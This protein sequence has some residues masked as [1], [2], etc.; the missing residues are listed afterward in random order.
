[1]LD[2]FLWKNKQNTFTNIIERLL[3][4]WLVRSHNISTHSTGWSAFIYLILYLNQSNGLIFVV[5][6]NKNKHI[7]INGRRHGSAK[8]HEPGISTVTE[9]NIGQTETNS[10][11][12]IMGINKANLNPG[13]RRITR[14]GKICWKDLPQW[15]EQDQHSLLSSLGRV[16][17]YIG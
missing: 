5:D 10:K 6:I 9:K 8:E 2:F 7:Y 14:R 15:S 11:L 12:T 4:F 1:M 3:H 13:L 17:R 16:H